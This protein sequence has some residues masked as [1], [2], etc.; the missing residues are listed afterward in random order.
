VPDTGRMSDEDRNGADGS[1]GQ[2]GEFVSQN[3]VEGLAVR[4]G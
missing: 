1:R 4:K 3:P 2:D